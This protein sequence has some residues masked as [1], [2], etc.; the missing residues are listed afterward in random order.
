MAF[1]RQMFGTIMSVTLWICWLSGSRAEALPRVHDFGENHSH[2]N[3]QEVVAPGKDGAESGRSAFPKDLVLL[4]DVGS[5]HMARAQCSATGH[6]AVAQLGTAT[7]LLPM[8]F[9]AL[10]RVSSEN[11]TRSSTAPL[12]LYRSDMAQHCSKAISLSLR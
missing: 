6:T 4:S 11:P 7:L 8:G 3:S 10:R 12:S 5:I 9:T 1:K 2:P